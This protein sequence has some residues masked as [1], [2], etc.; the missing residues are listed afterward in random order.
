[1]AVNTS[2]E[3]IRQLCTE[4][5]TPLSIARISNKERAV[6]PELKDVYTGSIITSQIELFKSNIKE[7]VLELAKDLSL[8]AEY[9]SDLYEIRVTI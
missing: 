8:E 7:R 6:S 5:D 2:V 4:Y 3:R 9:L 1:E